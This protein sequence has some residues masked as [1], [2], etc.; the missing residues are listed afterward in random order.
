MHRA[1]IAEGSNILYTYKNQVFH[2]LAICEVD[3][4]TLLSRYGKNENL[5]LIIRWPTLI[6]LR[7][8]KSS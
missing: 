3:I 8:T 2:A 7:L 4:D 6:M 1:F 5:L